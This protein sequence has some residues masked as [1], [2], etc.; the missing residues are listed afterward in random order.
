[1][2]H[3]KHV[4]LALGLIFHHIFKMLHKILILVI[5]ATKIY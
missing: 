1:M 2:L 4:Y 3:L 5:K